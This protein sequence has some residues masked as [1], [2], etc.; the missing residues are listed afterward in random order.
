VLAGADARIGEVIRVHELVTVVTSAQ[1]VHGAA[2]PDELEENLEDAQAVAAEDRA[3]PHDG[4]VEAASDERGRDALRAKLRPPVGFQGARRDRGIHRVLRRNAE[5]GARGDED[6]L[7]HPLGERGLQDVLRSADVDG[8]EG[9]RVLRD[10][11]LRGVMVHDAHP[12]GDASHGARVANIALYEANVD[13]T[14]FGVDEIEDRDLVRASAQG[15]DQDATEVAGSPGDERA[16]L[17]YCHAASSM[18]EVRYGGRPAFLKQLERLS[19][20]PLL[21]K[22]TIAVVLIGVIRIASRPASVQHDVAMYLQAGQLLLHGQRPYVDFIDLNPPLIVYLSAVPA[23]V[24]MVLRTSVV[25]T[26]LLMTACAAALSLFFSRRTWVTTFEQSGRDPL[27]AEVAIL[28]L[29]S[30]L[31]LSDAWELVDL[32]YPGNPAPDPRLSAIFGQREHLFIIGALPF[33]ATR[34]RRYEGGQPGS[35]GAILAGAVASLVTCLKP[36]FVLLLL[37]PEVAFASS[38]RK[39]PVRR[40]PELLAFVVVAA[41]YLAHFALLPEA[42]SAAWFTRWLPFAIH[43]YG[44]FNET[45]YGPLILRSWPALASLAVAFGATIAGD[46]PGRRF[47]RSFALMAGAAAVLYVLQK[48][49]WTY[50]AYP[51]RTCSIVVLACCL[52]ATRAL[53]T[54]GDGDARFVLLLSRRRI[55]Q[56]LTAL[57]GVAAI[58]CLVTLARIDTPRDVDRLRSRSQIMRTIES[59][60]RPGDRVLVA[61]TGVWD[62]YPALTLQNRTPGSRYLWLFP[63]PML[64]AEGPAREDLENEFVRDLA[65]D[66][67]ERRPK[68]LLLQTGRCFGCSR[69]SVDA[70]FREHPPLASALEDY[71]LKG[72]VRD[73]QELQVLVRLS[74]TP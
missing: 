30:A 48:K 59:L 73:G 62:P 50:H 68:L 29:A 6:G 34:F 22:L 16:T 55:G 40:A 32:P 13:W 61:T 46:P 4:H 36:P 71:A 12:L 26:A 45:S 35:P 9:V 2:P 21:P 15:F 24:A 52:A 41:A 1:D 51:A 5:D 23:A 38:L 49:G 28:A 63:I 74:S 44:V 47:I 37:A 20:G 8:F 42:V 65:E 70:F 14:A 25:P 72:T 31:F 33:L 39:I 54:K 43:G 66:I 60:T 64:R 67:R 19:S 57:A 56:I 10:R 18:A 27:L 3:W 69:T 11:N 7:R 58:G 17:H 53:G